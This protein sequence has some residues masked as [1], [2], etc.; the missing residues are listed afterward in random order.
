MHT[1]S[2][3]STDVDVL[4][5]GAG[6]SG[7]TTAISAARHGASVLLVERHE[8]LSQFP[9]ATGVRPRVMEIL[10]S[11]GLEEAVRSASQPAR[12]SMLITPMLAVP[13]T[14]ISIGLPQ[15]ADVA[16]VSPSGLAVCPQDRLEAILLAHLRDQ[17][18]G[19]E[20]DVWFG[21]ELCGFE[22]GSGGNG[23]RAVVQGPAGMRTVTA[24][25]LVGADGARSRVRADAGIA[26][27][28]LGSEGSH[29][30]ALFRADLSGLVAEP[31][32]AL[33]MTVAPGLEGMLVATGE[34][35]RWIYDLESHPDLGETPADWSEERLVERLRAVTGRA[36]LRPEILG[37]FPWDFGASVAA[38]QRRGPVFLVGDAAHRTTPRGATGMNTGIA[39]GHNLGWKLAWVARG[40]AGP[41]LLDS[42]EQERGPVGR[43]NAEASL[44]SRMGQPTATSL[45]QDF[46]VVY[47][48]DG[49]LDTG[50]L[51]GRRA[52]HAW[53]DVA[54][55]Q[56]STLDLF[57]GRL[58]V[59]SGPSGEQV[60]RTCRE[61]EASGVPIS[62][63]RIG[64]D[65]LDS[66]GRLDEI[67]G[68]G[69]DGWVVVR[70]DGY[71]AAS[72]PPG[73]DD[74]GTAVERQIRAALGGQPAALPAR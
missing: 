65:I 7:L 37:L 10:R 41:T 22:A 25:F 39:D 23:V 18:L 6:P 57:D 20:A 66:D 42:Y 8:H 71:V 73:R 27:D 61:L 17:R 52:P 48:S 44:V 62:A 51:S 9:K 19:F 30:S 36:D 54:G 5:V 49:I 29:L 40:L 1:P 35:N 68:L 59:I 50:P 26:L 63:Y 58:T 43:A 70:P 74:A 16:A 15:E 33:T 38:E 67:Y 21:H 4:V 28:Q 3:V 11:W 14:E 46:G 24:R 34:R 64:V 47:A 53:V 12:L 55:R 72:Q 69:R 2:S 13:G 31:P 45:D 56:R 60:L 32:H